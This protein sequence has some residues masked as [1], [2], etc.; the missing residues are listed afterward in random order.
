MFSE[1]FINRVIKGLGAE[2]AVLDHPANSV[3][4]LAK[5]LAC[6]GKKLLAGEVVLTWGSPKRFRWNPETW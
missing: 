1:K 5:M 6:K 3:V 4:R 2:A